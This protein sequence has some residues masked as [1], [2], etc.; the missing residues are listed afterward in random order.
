MAAEFNP[1]EQF[2]I[3]PL[4]PL[5]IGNV[6]VSFTNSSLF[7]LIA[8]VLA[9]ALLVVGTQGARLVPGRL[10]SMAELSYEFIANMIEENVG[11]EGMRYFP[12]IFTLF[13]FV[14]FGN[15]LGM[16][17]Y[18]FTYTSHIVVTFALAAVVFIGVTIIGLARHGLHF[19]KLFAPEG[20]PWPLLLLLVPIELIS[21]FIR[22]FTLSIRLFANMLAGH[23]ILA[24][25]AGFVAALGV[26]GIAPL[27]MDVGFILLEFLVA[28]LQAYIFTILTCLYLNDAIHLH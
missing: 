2:E 21:Y 12:F 11:T 19:F 13:M 22:P 25:F 27:A 28:G 24:V 23:A 14:L 3:K 6:D 15:L 16:V 8:V 7:M 26:L 5:H 9:T 10:Q 17:P 1:L 20:V 18:T 4:I